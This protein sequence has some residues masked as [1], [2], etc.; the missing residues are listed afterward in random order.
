MEEKLAQ[1][2]V[3][4]GIRTASAHQRAQAERFGV[5]MIEMRSF[6]EDRDLGFE[7]P[8]Y[9]TFDMD[10]LDPSCAPGVSHREA[11]GL[12]TRQAL[13]VLQRVGGPIVGAD[14]VEFNPRLDASGVTAFAAAK[15]AKEIAGRMLAGPALQP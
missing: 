10:A 2:L 6:R 5:E 1:R 4:V 14:I 12:S 9:V 15:L 3:Q 7:G 11:G 13:D 8:V